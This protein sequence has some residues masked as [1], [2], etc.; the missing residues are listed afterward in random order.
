ML[1]TEPSI[2]PTPKGALIL[3]FRSMNICSVGGRGSSK[4]FTLMLDI[5]AHC[6]DFGPDARPLVMRG[7]WAGLLELQSELFALCT[8]AY[9]QGVQR[10]K[11]D[12]T[13]KLPTGGI[14]QFSNIGDDASYNKLQGRTFTGHFLDE[15]GVLSKTAWMNAKRA[16][17]NL[18]VAPGKRAHKHRTANPGG[19]AHSILWKEHLSKASYW[20]PYQTE[21]GEWWVNVHSTLHDN[22]FIDQDAY[23]AQISASV[24]GDPAMVDAWV[25]GKWTALGGGMFADVWDEQVHILPE[26]PP[27]SAA[28]Y[29]YRIGCDWGTAAPCVGVL[30]GETRRE[31]RYG[32]GL[33]LPAGT[34]IAIDETDTVV[35][36]SD[37]S[38]GNGISPSAWAEQLK[39]MAKVENE[40]KAV[41]PVIHDDARGLASETVIQLLREAGI[42]AHKPRKKD[43][44]GTWA[45]L[46][47][48]LSNSKTGDGPGIYFTPRCR[49]LVETINEAP[50]SQSNPNDI[51]PKYDCDHGLDAYGYG[52]RELKTMKG[53]YG[54]IRGDY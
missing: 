17:S 53:R 33:Y 44:P 9:G 35:D 31:L 29:R 4:T 45:L 7:D 52:L 2:A 24:G 30:L 20:Q 6:E 5:L 51:D 12:G 11:A 32:S 21:N 23:V 22:P 15:S 48:L 50:R 41:P 49:Y 1:T 25:W 18:R 27:F 8:K 13:I 10:N 19:A 42:P 26:A 16:E 39:Y 28:H 54:R 47:Q 37:L 14:I 36:R 34:I 38:V 43:R 40:L 46:R 3:G